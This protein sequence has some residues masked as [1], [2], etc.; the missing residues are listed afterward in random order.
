MTVPSQTL[1]G[2][3]AQA[4]G[5]P[6][7]VL[8]AERD[9][10]GEWRMLGTR[11]F[12]E[13]VHRAALGLSIAGI[14]AGDRVAIMAPNRLDW[15]VANLA[16]L[17]AGAVSVPLY[18]TQAHDIVKHIMD[19]SG[20]AAIF[21][22]TPQR[23][24]ALVA[25]GIIAPLFISFDAAASEA[26][27]ADLAAL[28]CAGRDAAQADP[29]A[30]ERLGTGVTSDDLAMLIY[31]SGTTG[32]PKGVMLTHRNIASNAVDAF[33][34][35]A[36][37]VARGD[38]VLSILPFAH[39][40]ESTNLYG[41]YLLGCVIY[42]NARVEAL[43]DDLRTVRPVMM[44][45]VPR[46]FE[47][48]LVQIIVKATSAGG[49]RALLVPWALKTGRNYMQAKTSGH[50]IGISL[51]ARYALARA[52]AL[53]KIRPLLGLQNIKVCGS[54]SARLHPDTSL[55]FMSF[56]VRISEGYGLTECSPV[57]TVNE[58][59]QPHVGSVGT[60]IANVD[61]QLAADGEL[62]V[63]GPGVMKGY[64]RDAPATER[65]L[66]GG[67][68]HTGDIA[69]IAADGCVRIIDRKNELFKT[70]GGK[71]I[72]P[73]RI[74]SALLRS[75]YFNFVMVFGAGRAHPVA[76]IAP[77]WNTLRDKLQLGETAGPAELGRRSE[78]REFLST[79][80]HLQTSDLAPFEQIRTIAL[81][82]RD[83][84]IE[85]GELSPTL[86]IKRRVVEARYGGLIEAQTQAPVFA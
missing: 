44:L 73:A 9:A 14:R 38:A 53:S 11:A 64:Y 10:G 36:D 31:T 34:R 60:A 66:A 20:A 26:G 7:R 29:A 75:L 78:V 28:E 62:L 48:V 59:L 55:A 67:W 69:E 65:A 63:R 40:Y 72:A 4:L 50:A 76:L 77:N 12:L 2:L 24:A 39:I 81:L 43:L 21:V 80:A 56:G 70:S 58:P 8:F 86:K 19:D 49:V 18:A 33:A 84:S 82:P 32:R 30:I 83:L 52:L 68:L 27:F 42:L 41:Y 6:N 15:I 74:E 1:L 46:I 35:V 47:R 25:S 5:G 61:L 17:H 85:D 57:V 37:V 45:A 71:F 13:R 22:D 79:E 3:T 51:S 54:G 16:I 23:R